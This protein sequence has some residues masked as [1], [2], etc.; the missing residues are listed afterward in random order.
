MV[1]SLSLSIRLVYDIHAGVKANSIVSVVYMALFAD[2]GDKEHVF[3]PVSLTIRLGV[4]TETDGV[5]ASEVQRVDKRHDDVECRRTVN[6]RARPTV[7]DGSRTDD[8]TVVICTIRH[9]YEA[10]HIVRFGP[11]ILCTCDRLGDLYDV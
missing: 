3:S 6:T 2:F 8:P 11:S 5:A 7:K 4:G 10:R 1:V 9:Q